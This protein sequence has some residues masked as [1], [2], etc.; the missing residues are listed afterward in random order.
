MTSR[1][2]FW[3][4]VAQLLLE[5]DAAVE[6]IAGIQVVHDRLEDVE[7]L[8]TTIKELHEANEAQLKLLYTQQRVIE[9]NARVPEGP[10]GTRAYNQIGTSFIHYALN[11]LSALADYWCLGDSAVA[12]A[13]AAASASRRDS[14]AVDAMRFRPRM[15]RGRRAWLIK[16]Q[17][18]AG[19]RLIRLPPIVTSLPK[20]SQAEREDKK[21]FATLGKIEDLSEE[22]D[23]E[24]EFP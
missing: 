10:N 21:N 18:A 24:D 8:T 12:R 22:E 13:K 16:Q 19:R 5:R 9:S 4:A 14:G 3:D 2:V 11:A 20:G 17:C 6:N 7:R 23:S 15:A 1:D